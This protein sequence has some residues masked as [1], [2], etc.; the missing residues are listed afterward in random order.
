[1]GF[2]WNAEPAPTWDAG[3]QKIVGGAPPGAFDLQ[4]ADGAPMA[5]EWWSV[6]DG[7]GTTVGYGRLEIAWGDAEILL[8]T[9]PARQGTGV[10]G[11]VLDNLEREAAA[12]GVNYVY[13]TIRDT[14]PDREDVRAWLESHG[15]EG[16]DGGVLRKRVGRDRPA[17]AAGPA[18][19]FDRSVDMGPG[20]EEAGG[21]VDPERH[22][23]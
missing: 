16:G 9:D 20:R 15:F 17:P 18:P 19:S 13:N 11:F 10:G 21:Y 5:G 7:D 6:T 4:H 22:R 23:Y 14:H 2:T 3:K 12:R 1:M 8:A